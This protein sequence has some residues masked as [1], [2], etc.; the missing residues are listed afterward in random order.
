MKKAKLTM[1]LGASDNPKRYSYLAIK[2]LRKHG[3]PVIAVGKRNSV[4]GDVQ[5]LKEAPSEVRPHTITL[6][7]NSHNQKPYYDY[8]L[9]IH[10][11]RII[12]NPGAE[13][14]ELK[15]MAEDAGIETLEACSL[16]LLSTGN[17]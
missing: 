14:R 2:M 7:L 8:I 15:Q 10:P 5:V 12:F 9:T 13:N 3:H 6:Y 11:R 4:V 16:V 1:V 17:Y